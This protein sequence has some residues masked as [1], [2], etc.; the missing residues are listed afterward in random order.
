MYSIH[1]RDDLEKLKKLQ[2]TKSLIFKE[3]LKEKLGKQDFHYDLEEVFEPVTTKQVEANEKQ[4]QAL[5]DSTRAIAS[6]A[7]AASQTTVQAIKNQT[8]AIRESSNALN[9]NLQKSIKEGIQE[10]DEITNRN[11]QLLTSLV[12]SNQVDSSIVKTVSNLLSDKNKSQF[13]LEPIIQDYPNIF[14]INP[15]NPQQ[16]LIKGSTITFENGNS[17]NLNDP[18]LQYFI[19]NTQFDKPI[20]NWGSIYNF[21]NDMK[22]DLNY[23]DKK[24]IRYQFIKELYSRYQLQGFTQGYTQG[25]A[26]SSAQDFAQGPAQDYTQ[27]FAQAHDLQGF[28]QGSAQG[29]AGSSAQDYTQGHTQGFTGSGLRKLSRSYAN[30]EYSRSSTHSP[31]QQYI[32]LPSDPDELVD[33][34]KLL[35]FEKVGGN[36]SFLINEQIIAIIDK[37]LEY[38]CISPSQ[39]QN[40]QSYARS[41][42]IS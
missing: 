2:E 5:H 8:Q 6:A 36:D 18:D 14:T 34:L 31:A 22:Y 39:H 10:Y 27:G 42:L 32:F 37:L 16:V 19:T 41:N 23:G 26:G 15:H 3:R 24:S 38:E 1:T 25:Y 20:N 17:Y 28:T 13:S 4:I 11:N 35:Y 33:Q 21:L 29:Y 30:G 40:M 9:K 12:T 7:N